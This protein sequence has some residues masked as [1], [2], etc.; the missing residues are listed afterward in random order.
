MGR[1]PPVL[2][3]FTRSALVAAALAT[4]IATATRYASAVEFTPALQQVIAAA[5][6]EGGVKV[7]WPANSFG[8][9][10]ASQDIESAM[11]K[12]FGTRIKIDYSVGLGPPMLG[13]RVLQEMQASHAASADIL[14]DA[15]AQVALFDKLGLFDKIDFKSLLPDR[16]GDEMV[17]AEG[18][19]L[20]FASSSAG[21]L[22]NTRLSPER[23]TS[24]ADMVKPEWK[25]K[26]ATTPY[27]ASFDF[28]A[29]SDVWGPERAVAYAQ[30][31]STNIAGL[32]ECPATDRV[33]SGEF[34]AVV[35]DCG[36]QGERR[37]MEDGAPID[38]VIPTDLAKI[39]YYYYSI[40]KNSAHKNAARLFAIF[41]LTAPG[42]EILW[43]YWRGDLHLLPGSRE[44]AWQ[45][46]YTKKYGTAFRI[47]T[48]DWYLHHPEIAPAVKRMQAVLVDN[49]KK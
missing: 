49:N 34:L 5:D 35:M 38:Q 46:N 20:A 10:S 44:A 4:C 16:I 43:K 31:L 2:V 30:Q 47:F 33:I 12:M 19:A 13:F 21:I 18:A 37:E 14:I 24:L 36:S 6:Q 8:G 1:R 42:Q 7:T 22:Y 17:E 3:K 28:L 40:P 26:I 15:A 23:P 48:V 32:V 45:Q 39:S 25:G 29:A 11:N 27:L 41:M 9:A